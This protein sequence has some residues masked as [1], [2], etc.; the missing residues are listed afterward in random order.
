VCAAIT[1]LWGLLFLV[2]VR[3]GTMRRE[4]VQIVF[5]VIYIRLVT[6]ST[7]LW[8]RV[9]SVAIIKISAAFAFIMLT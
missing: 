5:L 6:I 2:V 7:H 3:Y 8:L 4:A 1:A 9:G